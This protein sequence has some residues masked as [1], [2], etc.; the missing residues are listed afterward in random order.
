MRKM[1][2]INGKTHLIWDSCIFG[3]IF[4][5]LCNP[6]GNRDD[7]LVAATA[8]E[9]DVVEAASAAAAWNSLVAVESSFV[10]N[11]VRSVPSIPEEHRDK[12][13]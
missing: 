12:A 9:A 7:L 6:G 2:F 13:C 10:E 4:G 5:Q 3:A 8:S 11:Y 1:E